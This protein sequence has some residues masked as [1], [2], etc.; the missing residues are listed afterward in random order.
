[1]IEALE[2]HGSDVTGLGGEEFVTVAVDFVPGG[3]FASHP[4]PTRTLIVRARQKDLVAR[5]QGRIPADELRQ[6]VEVMEY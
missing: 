1:V 3:F 4:R 6:R 2:A 5:A